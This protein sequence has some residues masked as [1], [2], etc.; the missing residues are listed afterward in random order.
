MFV[1]FPFTEADRLTATLDPGTNDCVEAWVLHCVPVQTVRVAVRPL[2]V[3]GW[4]YWVAGELL[5]LPL[6][7]PPQPNPELYWTEPETGLG[8]TAPFCVQF[9]DALQPPSPLQDMLHV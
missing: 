1:T 7:F 5:L 8:I 3:S 9:H 6:Q 4:T 2:A